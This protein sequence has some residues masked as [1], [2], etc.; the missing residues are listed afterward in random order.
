VQQVYAEIYGFEGA[1]WSFQLL[2]SKTS[3]A[4]LSSTTLS[5]T[6]AASASA[7]TIGVPVSR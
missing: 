6:A 7:E 2:P 1:F 3:T 4:T 5:S